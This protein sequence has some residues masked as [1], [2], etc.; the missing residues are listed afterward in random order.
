M[1]AAIFKRGGVS[2][3]PTVLLLGGIIIEISIAIAF[4]TYIFNQTNFAARLSSE[5]LAI[6]KAGVA[7]AIVRVINNKD[8]PV[9]GCPAFYTLSINNRTAAITICKDTCAGIGKTQIES[10]G[11]AF[12]QNRKLRAVLNVNPTTGKVDIESVQEIAV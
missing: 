8:C 4:L 2:A 6:A 1:A 12:L 10:S 9:A 5:A 11:A 7:D 3:L